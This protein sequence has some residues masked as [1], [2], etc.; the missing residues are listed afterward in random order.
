MK[1]KRNVV[2][3]G[4]NFHRAKGRT[5]ADRAKKKARVRDT[6]RRLSL[7]RTPCY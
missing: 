4:S 1:K 5:T 3:I 6:E 2:K 7:P